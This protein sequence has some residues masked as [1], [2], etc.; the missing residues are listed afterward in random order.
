MLGLPEHEILGKNWFDHFLPASNINEIKAIFAQAMKGEIKATGHYENMVLTWPGKERLFAW[1]N[2]LLKDDAEQI[3][4]VLC[5][6][7]DITER[8]QAEQTAQVLRDQ[9]IQSTKM[10]AVGHLTAGI[11]HDFNNILGAILGYTELSKHVIAAGTPE[12]GERYM[13]EI[14]KAIQRAKELIAQMLTFSRLSPGTRGGETPA[15]KLTPVVKEVVSLLRSSIPS[16]IELNYQ[17]ENPDLKSHIL[18]IHL[19]QIIL[20]LGINARDAIGEYGKIDITLAAQHVI[21]QVC[22]SCQLHYAGEFVKLTI[23]DTGSGIAEHIQKNIFNPFFTTKGVGKGTGMGLSVV[24]GLVHALGGHIQV[25]SKPGKGTALSILL[26]LAVTEATADVYTAMPETSAGTLAGIRI[27]V[28]D[29]EAAMTAILHEFLSLHGA[30]ITA[31]NSP[32]LAWHAFEQQ[33]Q[34]VDL[35]ITDETM[36][37]LSGMHLAQRMLKLRPE[38]PVILCTGYSTHA[39]PELAEQAGLAG[40]FHKP[41]QMSELLQ[42]LRKVC[43]ARGI[44]QQRKPAQ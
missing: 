40:F 7:E 43:L 16:T 12:V 2:S 21:R 30:K 10:E 14:L 4:G 13:E 23:L 32:L 25:E 38:L 24:H 5:S 22:S 26:P 3:S 15:I 11:A 33:P 39:T 29:D 9:L 36:P 18:P 34:R 1:N 41:L 19:H 37:G 8:K 44:G 31:Y 42:K 20:N 6:A 27:M 17:V 35:V 28:V